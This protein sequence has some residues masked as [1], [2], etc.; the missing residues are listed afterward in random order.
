MPFNPKEYLTFKNIFFLTILL[1]VLYISFYKNRE[2]ATV[3][4][5]K[6]TKKPVKKPN[7]LKTINTNTKA[8]FVQN[9]E[10]NLNSIKNKIN[11]HDIQIDTIGFTYGVQFNYNIEYKIDNEDITKNQY[12]D[13]PYYVP[14]ISMGFT[15]K[16]NGTGLR[17][18][19]TDDNKYYLNKKD[20]NDIKIDITQEIHK[21]K[22]IINI[23]ILKKKINENNTK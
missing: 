1:F 15:I 12:M 2:N 20:D 19:S 9:I 22:Q 21:I 5:K 4:S 11:K 18:L 3:V 16:N 13:T 23:N 7:N 6:T 10:S 8:K 17:L 14:N